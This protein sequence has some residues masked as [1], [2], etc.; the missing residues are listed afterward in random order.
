MKSPVNIG[1]FGFGCVGQ[2]FYNLYVQTATGG[3]LNIKTKRIVV[4]QR[5]KQRDIANGAVVSYEDF[6]I[7]SDSEI[8]LLVEAINNTDDA[9]II[10]RNALTSGKTLVSAS[11]KMLAENFQELVELQQKYNGRLFYE[12]SSAGS[13]PIIR[14]LEEY[15]AN[16][17]IHAIEAILNGTSNFI[18]T[19]IF[20]D[21]S[22]YEAALKLAQEKGFAESDPTL[23][24]EGYDAVN[25]LVIISAHAIGTIVHPRDIFT[26]G[27]RHLGSSDVQYALQRGWRI[28]QV[29]QAF[30]N[31]GMLTLSVTPKFVKSTEQLY[32][33]NE[34]NN[35]V[36]VHAEFSGTQF[37]Y[38][39]GAGSHPTGSAVMADVVASLGDFSYMY[40]KL[41]SKNKPV[42][43]TDA[44]VSV[45]L[46]YPNSFDMAK[47]DF[48]SIDSQIKGY[49]SS[50]I[51]GNISLKQL[52]KHVEL[53]KQNN[54][55]LI[56]N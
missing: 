40:H 13:I 14:T 21:Y 9:L 49:N 50:V 22:N 2:G 23:D 54:V 42:Y 7:L 43:S 53:L 41:K 1:L 56:F 31:N 20:N 24:I 12:A 45:Y 35:G 36:V 28:K 11:K 37:Y 5:N 8:R 25:K 27:I 33:V 46:R 19:S 47:L 55:S 39:K 44:T 30:T 29:A 34:E 3:Q 10:A 4:K 38:G 26:Y 18:L 17:K 51:S 16:E 52:I 6:D 15:F 48:D 32:H